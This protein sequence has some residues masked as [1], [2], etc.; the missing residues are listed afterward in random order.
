MA[1]AQPPAGKQFR[2][3]AIGGSIILVLFLLSFLF[4]QNFGMR[5]FPHL[6]TAGKSVKLC[7]GTDFPVSRNDSQG[8]APDQAVRLAIDE[9]NHS[10]SLGNNVTLELVVLDDVDP[11]S[12]KH[13]PD[14]GKKNMQ[15]LIN[16]SCVVGVVGPGN[17]NVAEAEIPLAAQAG[18]ALISPAATEPC[19][20]LPTNEIGPGEC[21]VAPAILH[22]NGQNTFF[23]IPANDDVQ[24]KVEANLVFDATP[25]TSTN[26]GLGAR[27]VYIVDDG[28]AF[29][30]ELALFFENHFKERGGHVLG[31]HS[32]TSSDLANISS[33]ASTIA[34]MHPPAVFFSGT[35]S[36]G[37]SVLLSALA[38]QGYKGTF[39]GGDGIANDPDFVSNTGS[40]ST[41]TFATLAEP[42]L[43]GQPSSQL[44]D[45]QQHFVSNY[46]HDY[47]S[48]PGRY[49]ANAYD[50]AR[51]LI[52]AIQSLLQNHQQVTRA[53]VLQAVQQTSY[54]GV[55]GHITFDT[56][57]DNANGQFSLFKVA[58]GQWQFIRPASAS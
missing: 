5:L 55:T 1:M 12:G 13:S 9:S 51:I 50:A 24:G 48:C 35:T 36:T 43:C 29:G 17:S 19:L 56:N 10:R 22:P 33:L 28:E 23:R 53:S 45:V 3:I 39:V 7:I 49:G 16:T 4:F 37:G 26:G 2:A 27:N 41:G 14:Q 57:G 6:P 8:I 42:D 52:Q 15:Q 18:L 38:D 47:R 40:A 46:A 20:T 30:K 32:L 54:D 25:I 21:D 44:T 31:Q 34:R 11:T 58:N